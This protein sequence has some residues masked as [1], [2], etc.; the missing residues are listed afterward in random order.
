[1]NR[2]TFMSLATTGTAACLWTIS[3]RS[4][5]AFARTGL[6]P[7]EALARLKAGN[8]KFVNAPQLCEAGLREERANTAGDQSPWATILTCSDSRVAPE[9]I[10]GG[11]GLGELFVARNAGNVADTAVLGTIEYGAEHL[12]SP[13][14]VVLG[15]Q[16]CGAVQAACDVVAKHVELQGSIGPMVEA[17]VPAAKSQEGK[18]GDFVDNTVRENARRNAAGILAGS[19][20]IRE[21]VHEGQ[22][23]V[24]YAYYDLDSG[25]VDFID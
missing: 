10:F 13:L 24:V 2:R 21:M 7:D 22:V 12:G 20:I 6:S 15:H 5:S 4:N 18:P 23:K 25:M 19:D 14:V 8:A 1:M 3:G 11:V 17:I 16:R 9:L